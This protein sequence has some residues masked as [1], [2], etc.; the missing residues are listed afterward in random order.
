MWLRYSASV[1]G[2]LLILVLSYCKNDTQ[3]D[4]QVHEYLNMDSSVRYVGID[5]CKSCHYDKYETFLKTGMGSSFDLASLKKTSA[6][7]DQVKP[8]YDAHLN[9][10]YVPFVSHGQ[11]YI[12]EYRLQNKD[13]VHSRIER[14]AYIIGSGH[15]T[16]SHFIEENGFVFQAPL[17]FYTQ[18]GTW[19]LPPG[20]ENG[21]NTRFDRKI[22]LECMSCHNAIPQLV[23][24]SE[25]QYRDLPHGIN[26]ERCHGPGELHVKEKQ[27]G[28][29]VD[30]TKEA[31]RTIVNP[32]RLVWQRQIDI[33]QRCHLQ[34]DAVLKP[35]KQFTDFRPGMKL[36][37]VFDQFSPE[38]KG[39]D[40]FVMAAH[41]ERFQKSKCFIESV[42]G[43]INSSSA[44]IGFTCISCHDPHVSVRNTRSIVFNQTCTSCH[45]N[46]QT[47]CSAKTSEL[48]KENNNCVKC[49]MPSSGTSDIPHVTVHDHY[50]RK[51]GIHSGKGTLIGLRCITNDN[52]DMETLTEAYLSYFEKFEANQLYLSKA[53]TLSQ[54]LDP[55]I[56]SNLIIL[57]HLSYLNEE[58]A[59]ITEYSSQAAGIKDPWTLYRIAKAFEHQN[60]LNTAREWFE[61]AIESQNLNIDFQVQY[62]YLLIRLNEFKKA[63]AVLKEVLKMTGKNAEAW[64]CLGLAQMKLNQASDAKG[65][66]L[67]ALSLNPDQITAL[68]NLKNLEELLGNKALSVRYEQRINEIK[69]RTIANTRR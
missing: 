15:H 17:T 54:Q 38:Y 21:N 36:S 42:K 10:Y 2:L 61:K 48:K 56:Q 8:V 63:E 35:G 39:G 34:G 23:R 51:P 40:E 60:R 43:D 16:N 64:A 68:Q 11:I 53:K 69:D 27:A 14:V 29:V 50:I 37:D 4:S 22:G 5:A 3:K 52:P 31:D 24:G 20:F 1:L 9:L 65:S 59:R 18:K 66:F 32:K 55:K 49:H 62:A 26:C 19:D 41:A 12:K 67:K 46:G 25:N 7:F 33:C 13:T 6:E 30:V 28:K 47:T 44:R 45:S 57:I 58:Y